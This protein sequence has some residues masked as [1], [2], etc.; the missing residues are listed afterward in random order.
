MFDQD[1]ELSYSGD[2]SYKYVDRL[3]KGDSQ[4]IGIISPYISDYYTKMLLKE[5]GN[6]RIRVITSQSSLGY[7]DSTL[8]NFI[9]KGIKG[10]LKALL[11]F[12]ILDAISI[13]L[14]F[15]YTTAIISAII[16]I[17]ALLT[18]LRY[19]SQKSNL[20]VKVIR[21]RFV[22]EKVYLAE[23]E[24]IIGSA[25]LTYN[26]MHKNIEHIEVIKDRDRING[27]KSH[28]EEMWKRN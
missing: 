20:Q 15:N 19:R 24:A 9:I 23:N 3:I 21:D 13:Y 8:G 2:S 11:F 26:G 7:R 17:T 4:E 12:L 28:F 25:N 22:H 1:K 16:A 5:T 6:K 14:Q 10:Y 27:L 18:Y